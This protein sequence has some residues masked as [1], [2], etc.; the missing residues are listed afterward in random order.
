MTI[1]G[2]R[3][4]KY[5]FQLFRLASSVDRSII[6]CNRTLTREEG[7]NEKVGP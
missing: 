5:E 4:V 1:E 2:N 6:P 7:V 3:S